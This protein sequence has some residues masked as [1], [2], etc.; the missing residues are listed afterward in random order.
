MTPEGQLI[1]TLVPILGLFLVGFKWLDGKFDSFRLE[2]KFDIQSLDTKLSGEIK[3]VRLASETAH[4]EIQARLGNVETTLASHTEKFNTIGA[5]MD[6][7]E[8]KIDN[9]G[10]IKELA[11]SRRAMQ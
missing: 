10:P 5:R 9:I 2:I 4:K 1:A 3:D 11:T 8:D 7:I 6:C